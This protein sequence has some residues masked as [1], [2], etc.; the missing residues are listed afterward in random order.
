MGEVFDKDGKSL[1]L[2]KGILAVKDSK[3]NLGSLYGGFDL[4]HTGTNTLSSDEIVLNFKENSV[5]MTSYFFEDDS[6]Q[7]KFWSKEV[8]ND[9]VVLTRWL[10][11]DTGA[12]QPIDNA[13]DFQK[14]ITSETNCLDYS[15]RNFQVLS[16]TN[17]KVIVFRTIERRSS[18]NQYSPFEVISS[19]VQILQRQ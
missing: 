18:P 15:K 1:R 11:Q 16:V 3:T 10:S 19:G 17:N 9:E 13:N 6:Y 2:E 12:W 14:C 4:I 5:G 8:Q 7:I